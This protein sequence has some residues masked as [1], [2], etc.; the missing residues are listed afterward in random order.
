[1]GR[2]FQS[3]D[4]LFHVVVGESGRKSQFSRR[5]YERFSGGPPGSRQ[6][7]TKKVIHDLFKR[8]SRP[9]AFFVQETG[10]IVIERKSGSHILMLHL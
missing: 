10:N 2:T 3:L 7:E 4:Q 6:S 8:G 9:P 1:V 5:H